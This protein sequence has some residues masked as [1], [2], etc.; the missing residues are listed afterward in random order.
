M[1][2]QENNRLTIS[3]SHTLGTDLSVGALAYGCWRLA[4]TGVDEAAVKIGTA[5]DAGMTLIDTADIYGGSGPDGFGEAEALLGDVLAANPTLRGR[6]VLATK[7]GIVRGLPYNSTK[8]YLIR[9]CEASL[10]RL[11]TDVI[12]LYQ[13]HRPDLLTGHDEVADALLALQYQGKIRE[14]GV[15]N[16]TPDQSRALETHLGFPVASQQPE[17]SALEISPLFDGVLDHAMATG[18]RILAWSPLAGGGLLSDAA[19]ATGKAK[20]VITVLDRL[21]NAY[22]TDRTAVALA[23]L[24]AHPSGVIPI[25]GTQTPAR[26]TA[27]TAA[28]DVPLTRRDWYDILEASRGARMP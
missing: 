19:E 8:D 18:A 3:R 14:I 17:F 7:G 1:L 28:F 26:I 21:A 27:A 5:L 4:G 10:K 23:F 12:D 15:S 6:M 22:G 9:A 2:E 20:A 24:L 11:K 25:I 13:I 16:H